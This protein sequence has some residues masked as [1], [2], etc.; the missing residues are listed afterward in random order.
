MLQLG[1]YAEDFATLNFNFNTHKADGTPI[2]L[3]GSPAVSVYKNSTT[4]S[5]A[6]ITLS[7]DYDSLTGLNHVLIDLSSDAFYAVANDYS[8]VITAGTVDGISVVGTVVAQFS[9]E[10]RKADANVVNAA[11]LSIPIAAID[12]D[13]PCTVISIQAD[14]IDAATFAADAI[15]AAAIKAD[16]VTKIQNGLATPTNITAGTITNV[17]NLTNAPSSGDFTATMKTSL[18]TAVGTAQTGDSFARLGAPAGA[19]ISADIAAIESQTDDIGAA[20]A[21]LTAIPWNAAWDAEVQSEVADALAVYDPPTYAEI[22]AVLDAITTG[23]GV[24]VA[25]YAAGMSPADLVLITPARKL[26]TNVSGQVDLIDAPNATAVTAI[27]SALASA[28]N[29]ATVDGPIS[30]A[31]MQVLF[32]A[33][34]SGTMA[35]TDNGGGSYTTVWYRQDGTTPAVT[36]DTDATGRTSV[37]LGTLS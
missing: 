17:T 27:A 16:A 34:L 22:E 31:E 4:Q 24:K 28:L 26:Y 20:G 9:I 33:I 13:V 2:A 7:V 8:V 5:T 35:V 12:G 36:I 18:G 23:T 11:A 29:A 14:A 19:S 30:A 3:A 6:G 32:V 1:N 37:T 25:T 15:T 10:A 21:G